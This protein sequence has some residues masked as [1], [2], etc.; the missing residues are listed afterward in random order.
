MASA[1][2]HADSGASAGAAASTRVDSLH[3]PRPDDWHLHLRDGPAL[4]SLMASMPRTMA[5]AIVM[6]N[7][8]PPVATAAD[9]AAYR[10]R[11][12]AAR[13]PGSDF[14]PLMTLY[15]TDGTTPGDIDAA[16]DGGVVAA[17][18]YPAGA[19]TNS[20]AGV[21]DIPGLDAVLARLAARGL[22]L[23]L[24]GEVT[25]PAVDIFDREAAFL[26][27]PAAGILARHPSLKVVL[28]HVTT[29]AGVAFVRAGGARVA[30]TI[31]AHHLLFNR[32]ALFDG[33]LRPH[34]YCLPVLKTEAD[35]AALVAAAAS[36]SPQFFLGTDSAPHDAGAKECAC[37]AAGA[38]TAHAALE[39]YAGVF[40]AAGA[41]PALRAFA[42]ENGPAFYGLRPNAERLPASSVRLRRAPWVVPATYALG[43]GAVVPLGAGEPCEWKA[44]VVD[45]PPPPADAA[46]GGK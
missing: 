16:A 30:G 31:T 9:A 42:C 2:G 15:L 25:D 39:L 18:L 7:L 36:G 3:L 19:T 45:E 23:L 14:E 29:A 22:P 12:L 43:P 1:S 26:A 41:L 34:R 32:N 13:P 17:K 8:R 27:G 5:R 10:A 4:A 37:G 24:H 21:R 38:F 20:H 33:G 6:P 46:A 40:D 28:E 11:I 35:R 44:E